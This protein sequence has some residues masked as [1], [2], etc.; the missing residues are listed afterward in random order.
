[1]LKKKIVMLMLS[2]TLFASFIG[3]VSAK[4]EMLTYPS[5]KYGFSI[6]YPK[7]WV[8]KEGSDWVEFVPPD[9]FYA[10]F[11]YEE[12]S[13]FV[14]IGIQKI[15]AGIPLEKFAESCKER[16]T[17]TAAKELMGMVKIDMTD[18][19]NGK[20]DGE[21]FAGYTFTATETITS[22]KIRMGTIVC[23][24]KGTMGYIVFLGASPSL[25]LLVEDPYFKPILYSFRFTK[26]DSFYENN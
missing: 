4:Q 16:L 5:E 18:T 3:M 9:E 25:Y 14:M 11:G 20:I 23:F 13:L 26:E 7:D 19:L 21:P 17:E 8:V 2:V 1:M 15:P 22:T 24:V 12:N 6:D 10:S